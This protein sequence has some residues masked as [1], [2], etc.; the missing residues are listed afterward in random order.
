MNT[1]KTKFG[2][3]WHILAPG[4]PAAGHFHLNVEESSNMVVHRW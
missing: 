1:W 4:I 2:S 3:L